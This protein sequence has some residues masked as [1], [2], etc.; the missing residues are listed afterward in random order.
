VVHPSQVAALNEAFAP[1]EAELDWARRVVAGDRA[2]R[3]EGRG[4]FQLDGRM[5]DAPVVR[6]AEETLALAG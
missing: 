2:A 5:V 3:A 1:T 6:R 4:A